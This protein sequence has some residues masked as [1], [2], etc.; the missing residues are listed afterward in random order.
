MA[1]DKINWFAMS[2]VLP[3][4]CRRH[5][6]FR[7]FSLPRF[8]LPGRLDQLRLLLSGGGVLEVEEHGLQLVERQLGKTPQTF[9]PPVVRAIGVDIGD[10]IVQQSGQRVA[11]V[12]REGGGPL[13]AGNNH[14]D[15]RLPLKNAPL[16]IGGR[17]LLPL[18][19]QQP[20]LQRFV[21]VRIGPAE[22]F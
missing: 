21:K 16:G 10:R 7:L 5:H 8:K 20:A 17:E 18:I 15:K 6:W 22:D 2:F 4:L 13:E 1:T 11:L 14:L 12:G 3:P 19:F 9:E